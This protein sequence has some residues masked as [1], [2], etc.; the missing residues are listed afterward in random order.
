MNN[1]ATLILTY[2][3]KNKKK[4]EFKYDQLFIDQSEY[5]INEGKPI[6]IEFN[7]IESEM[8]IKIVKAE[9]I[10]YYI[11]DKDCHYLKLFLEIITGF[12]FHIEAI[13]EIY[14]FLMI[15]SIILKLYMIEEI[16]YKGEFNR[17]LLLININEIYDIFIIIK[18]Y[19]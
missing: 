8:R 7:D 2:I 6:N 10:D 19:I 5:K 3:A 18:Y 15:Q 1:K 12:Y 17:R 14:Y 16:I 11:N 13:L 4:E 9:F